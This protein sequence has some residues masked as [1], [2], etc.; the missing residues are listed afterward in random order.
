MGLD[1]IIRWFLPKEDHFYAFLEQQATVAHEA[2]V[3]LAKLKEDGA[4]TKVVCSEVQDIEHRGDKI[5]HDIEE[6]LAKTFVTPIDRED[7]QKL[8]SELDDV[9][10]LANAAARAFVL[11]SVEKPT[12]PMVALMAI[13]VRATKVLNDAIPNLRK[14]QYEAL[15]EA[16][17]TL[18][19]LEKE[20]DTVYR[21][22]IGQL[23]GDQTDGANGPYRESNMD[24]KR[25]IRERE[26][27][28]DLEKAVDHCDHVASTLAYLAV[29]HG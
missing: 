2:A 3:A 1:S 11:F 24:A 22:A 21:D 16:A 18:R 4:N 28:E 13:L 6:A 20:G 15:T 26:V 14:H 27:L 8:S 29:K 17:R 9:A 5:V 19:A 7:I 10:D 23:F 25:L 12:A